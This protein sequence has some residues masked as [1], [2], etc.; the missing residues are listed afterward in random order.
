M[1]FLSL[2]FEGFAITLLGCEK[3]RN[4]HLCWNQATHLFAL[5]FRQHSDLKVNLKKRILMDLP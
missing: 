1:S 5:H 4:G 3:L 2:A